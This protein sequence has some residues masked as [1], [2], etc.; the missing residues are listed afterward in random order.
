MVKT[1]TYAFIGC[2]VLQ[3]EMSY[4][5]S[6]SIRFFNEFFFLTVRYRLRFLTSVTY[7]VLV[8]RRVNHFSLLS[9]RFERGL[10]SF[11]SLKLKNS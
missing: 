5:Y 1:Q 11:S 2:L 7:N 6:L 10:N 8:G 4:N 3:F 9:E